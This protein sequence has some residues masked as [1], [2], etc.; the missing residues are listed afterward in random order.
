[1]VQQLKL[2]QPPSSGDASAP[3][4]REPGFTSDRMRL[5]E[6]WQFMFGKNPRRCGVGPQRARLIDA[7][8]TVYSFDTLR[9]ALDGAAAD[10]FIAERGGTF[11]SIE[12]I[13]R[14]EANIERYAEAGERLHRE[15]AL[16]REQDRRE[17]RLHPDDAVSAEE[18][19]LQREALRQWAW[20]RTGVRA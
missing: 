3:T 16:A 5:V 10:S 7:W 1:M 12:W 14:D 15:V 19:A 11:T 6:H 20:K 4:A 8:L 17:A 9:L 18:A 13:L 2:V